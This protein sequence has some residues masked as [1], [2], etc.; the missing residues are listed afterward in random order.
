[1]CEGFGTVLVEPSPKVHFQLANGL[2]KTSVPGAA[3]YTTSGAKPVLG[4]AEIGM[5]ILIRVA[6]KKRFA[7]ALTAMPL[8]S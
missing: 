4:V 6:K 8:P 5:F 7:F 1:M 3:N 2:P